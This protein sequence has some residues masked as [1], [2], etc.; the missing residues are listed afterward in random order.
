MV[1]DIISY[2]QP[3]LHLS[4]LCDLFLKTNSLVYLHLW[5]G[6]DQC[7]WKLC[8]CQ[9]CSCSL[10]QKHSQIHFHNKR[11]SQQ[12]KSQSLLLMLMRFLKWMLLIKL[13]SRSDYKKDFLK[14]E[15]LRIVHLSC[16]VQK[17]ESKVFKDFAA[18][19]TFQCH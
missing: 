14:K 19:F 15:S 18:V 13:L 16:F 3:F 11:A 5:V 1:A 12:P 7:C 6:G 9:W 2:F 8:V 17:M 10:C 4:F